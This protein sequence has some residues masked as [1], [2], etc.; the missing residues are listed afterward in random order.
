MVGKELVRTSADFPLRVRLRKLGV[1][2][3]TEAAVGEWHGD[4][5]TIVN[6]LDGTEE[7]LPFDTLVLAT[8]NRAETDLQE[9]L[10]GSGKEI[11][12]VGDCVAPRQFQ[13]A[14]FEGRRLGLRL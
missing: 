14:T 1:V 3:I 9:A 10:A 4:G 5:A 13:N 7:R 11:H 6:L 8:A 2:A 12:A